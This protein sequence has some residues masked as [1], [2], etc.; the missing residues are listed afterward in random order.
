MC[1]HKES[2]EAVES[3]WKQM[4]MR[5]EIE[6]VEAVLQSLGE[7]AFGTLVAEGGGKGDEERSNAQRTNRDHH[8]HTD[9]AAE[10]TRYCLQIGSQEYGVDG[11][12]VQSLQVCAQ[13]CRR[14]CFRC[15]A[16]L[17]FPGRPVETRLA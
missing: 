7:I 6:V 5:I 16:L 2:R 4:E 8:H 14:R 1:D 12:Q 9:S 15:L 3:S 10:Q 13:C 17:T 11:G